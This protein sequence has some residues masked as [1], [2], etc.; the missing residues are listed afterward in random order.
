M[1]V[2]LFL[3]Y[4]KKKIFIH[5]RA[6][7]GKMAYNNKNTNN[8]VTPQSFCGVNYTVWLLWLCSRMLHSSPLG[9][10]TAIKSLCLSRAALSAVRKWKRTTVGRR[11]MEAAVFILSLVDC[12]AL[13]FLSVYF[14]SFSVMSFLVGVELIRHIV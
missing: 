11:K 8:L 4:N 13:I 10:S 14:V 5:P 7:W 12:C 2:C 9:G 6:I 3:Q 1:F